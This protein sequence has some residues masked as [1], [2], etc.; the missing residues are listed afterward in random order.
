MSEYCNRRKGGW[1]CL[2]IRNPKLEIRNKFEGMEIGKMEK[3][4]GRT[5]NR[6]RSRNENEIKRV[7]E[8]EKEEEEDWTVH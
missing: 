5:T 8:D 2:K 3:R 7:D 4:S 6:N 1:E